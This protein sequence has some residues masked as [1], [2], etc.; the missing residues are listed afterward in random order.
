[1][2]NVGE[3]ITFPLSL[4]SVSCWESISGD[5]NTRN[6]KIGKRMNKEK[7]PQVEINAFH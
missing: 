7:I 5:K 3:A 2:G 6:S 1:M 4:A